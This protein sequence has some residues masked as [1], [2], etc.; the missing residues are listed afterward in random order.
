M[1]RIFLLAT[2]LLVATNVMAQN[3]VTGRIAGEDDGKPLD[4]AE[5]LAK[6][7]EEIVQDVRSGLDGAFEML[8]EKGEYIIEVKYIGYETSKQNIV[9]EGDMDLGEIALKKT[10]DADILIRT[11][12]GYFDDLAADAAENGVRMEAPAGFKKWDSGYSRGAFYACLL[13]S[14]DGEAELTYMP[15]YAKD[16][17]AIWEID[18]E[19][20]AAY[21]AYGRVV[22]PEKQTS[23]S[24]EILY[25]KGLKASGKREMLSRKKCQTIGIDKGYIIHRKSN[26]PREKYTQQA[27]VILKKGDVLIEASLLMT[28]E[29]KKSEKRYLKAIME[30]IRFE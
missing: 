27:I 26:D 24:V 28:D 9:V 22:E 16:H 12:W 29:G 11:P 6:A 2:M 15:V 10:P 23:E 19:K 8:V 3:R 1:K 7:G 17:L 25:S 18:G 5:V 21:N 20:I 14:E 30:A 4:Y 13:H